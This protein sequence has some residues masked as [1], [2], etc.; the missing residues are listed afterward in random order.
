MKQVYIPSG[1]AISAREFCDLKP[2][3]GSLLLDVVEMF[4]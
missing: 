3:R 2:V 1:L 4:P